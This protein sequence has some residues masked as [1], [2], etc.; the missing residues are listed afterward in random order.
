MKSELN[1]AIRLTVGLLT[2]AVTT[3]TA[4]QGK[5]YVG[6]D[7]G[8]VVTTDTEIEEWFGST[9]APNSELSFDPGFRLGVRG[10][11]GVTDWFDA[12]VETGF[13]VNNIDSATGAAETDASLT[14]FPLL[15]NARFH[16]PAF[17]GVSPYFGGGLGMSTTYLWADDLVINS[18]ELDGTTAGFA[19][20]Y[21]AFAGLRFAINEHMSLS[22]EYHYFATTGTE[23][24][25][26]LAVGTFSDEMEIGDTASHT[27]T[28]GFYY[29]F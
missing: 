6:G 11:Y 13:M 19:F 2:I 29:T 9:L 5:F 1:R 24:D 15:I 17:H 22:L 18:I 3:A 25:V 23:M 26:D 7:I 14:Q 27:A 4:E 28:I 20:A 16:C 10:G 12:E 8:A 21:Q